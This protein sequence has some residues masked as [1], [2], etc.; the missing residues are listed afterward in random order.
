M[1]LLFRKCLDLIFQGQTVWFTYISQ[2]SRKIPQLSSRANVFP[3]WCKII[4]F[5]HF[6]LEL[7]S[8]KAMKAIKLSCYLHTK[9]EVFE[10][11]HIWLNRGSSNSVYLRKW[12][13]NADSMSPLMTKTV[14]SEMELG[15]F[16]FV[17][18]S[19]LNLWTNKI[20]SLRDNSVSI[21]KLN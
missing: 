20:S 9:F 2:K 16:W 18:C 13:E 19:Q 15:K 14:I 21:H 3:I 12:G 6:K 8:Y 5:T 10:N 7:V 11:R 1:D 4:L 17:F